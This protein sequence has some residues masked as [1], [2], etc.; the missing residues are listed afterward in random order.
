MLTRTELGIDSSDFA[1]LAVGDI[2]VNKNHHVLVEAMAIPPRNFKLFI[3]G[4][5]PQ[6]G[7][8]NHLRQGWVSPI[9]LPCSDSVAISPRFSTRVTYSAFHLNVRVCPCL[10]SRRWL[11][12]HL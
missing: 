9:A 4:D 3:A 5:G 2:T 10:F 7:E 12:G 8:W 1:V 11:R 6:R